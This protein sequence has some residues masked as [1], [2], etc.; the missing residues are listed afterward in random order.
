MLY[1]GQT[2]LVGVNSFMASTTGSAD[3]RYGNLG[4]FQAIGP[5]LAWVQSISQ[6]PEPASIVLGVVCALIGWWAI[7]K[8]ASR[9]SKQQMPLA[10]T[11]SKRIS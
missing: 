7:E 4:G 6:V 9:Q 2:I 11:K 10:T 3:G 5:Q 1:N 8:Q